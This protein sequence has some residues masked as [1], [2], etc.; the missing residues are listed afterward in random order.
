MKPAEKI[1]SD[2]HQPINGLDGMARHGRRRRRR[3]RE[4]TVNQ[5][6]DGVLS[7]ALQL[8]G[9]SEASAKRSA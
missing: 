4:A 8:A 9:G 1:E 7:M 2:P 5:V 6:V 3:G